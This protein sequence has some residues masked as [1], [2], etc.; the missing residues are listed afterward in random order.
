MAGT[1]PSNQDRCNNDYVV[2]V[3]G[4]KK[5]YYANLLKRYRS[6]SDTHGKICERTSGGSLLEVASAT[7]LEA[8]GWNQDDS[9]DGNSLLELRTCRLKEIAGD[10]KIS[11]ELTYEERREARAVLEEFRNV[12]TDLSGS[13]VLPVH[14][15][16]LTSDHPVKSKPYAIPFHMKSELENDIRDMLKMSI[17]RASESRYASP[18]AFVWK[19]NETNR[20]WVD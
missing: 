14:R 8:D 16:Q 3:R 4:K 1:I 19:P 7:I 20:L 10:V 5:I 12:F 6:R 17:I 15:I 13:T 18:V 2:E 9:V 11:E